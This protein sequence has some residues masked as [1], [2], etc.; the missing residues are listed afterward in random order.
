MVS[1]FSRVKAGL[2]LRLQLWDAQTTQPLRT[3]QGHKW[4]VSAVAFSS[5][6]ISI[7]T[8]AELVREWSIADVA[9]RLRIE[10]L[11]HH[12]QI[13]WSTGELQYATRLDGPWQ[14]I[15]NALSPMTISATDPARF[16]RVRTVASE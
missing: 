12:T 13:T 7:L 2:S 10:K 15:T 5:D 16:Y 11:P 6:G 3:F 8:G 9:A 14:T 1:T 4:G